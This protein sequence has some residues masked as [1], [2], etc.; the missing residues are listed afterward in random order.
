MP[1]LLGQ[2]WPTAS[3]KLRRLKLH[4]TVH[5]V[6]G[7]PGR[8]LAQSPHAGVAAAPGMRVTVTVGKPG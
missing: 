3:A 2:R 6:K 7:K 5:A 4:V 8:I 1:R